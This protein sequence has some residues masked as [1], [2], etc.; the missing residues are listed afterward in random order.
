MPAARGRHRPSRCLYCD[1]GTVG[2]R[3]LS[4]TQIDAVMAD[5][6]APL[7]VVNKELLRR[8][9]RCGMVYERGRGSNCLG[10]MDAGEPVRFKVL[11][12]R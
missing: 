6:V 5:R 4:R 12:F 11:P 7:G 10:F 2:Q 3:P 9:D 1:A 8:C